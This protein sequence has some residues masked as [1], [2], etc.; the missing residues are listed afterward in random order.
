MAAEVGG[1]VGRAIG[2]AIN[3]C[4]EVRAEEEVR[5]TRERASSVKPPISGG[6]SPCCSCGA[7]EGARSSSGEGA[8]ADAMAPAEEES[9]GRSLV[10]TAAGL[11]AAIPATLGYNLFRATI[12]G[13][14]ETMDYF[15]LQLLHHLQQRLLP[16]NEKI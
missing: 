4:E 14:T 9:D 10:A 6:A 5:G 8:E 2:K 15:A 12:R 11:F 3:S 7:P 1:E 13:M 16:K